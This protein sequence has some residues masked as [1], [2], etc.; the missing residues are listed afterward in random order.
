MDNV[1]DLKYEKFTLD[2]GL[3]VIL[4]R[5]TAIPSVA[6]NL[7][8]KVGSA[9]EKPGKTGLAHLFEHM[10]FQGSLNVPKEMHF[11]YIQEAGGTLNGST[12]TDRT[13]YYETLPAPALDLALWLESDRMGF[14]LPALTQEKLDNQ[15][16]VVMNERRQRYDNQP[17]GRAWEI[18]FSNL[19]PENHP[20]HWP[21]IG[22]MKDIESYTLEDVRAFFE[23]YYAPNN[24]SLV[25]AGN[26]D[27]DKA[28]KSAEQY[29]SEIKSYP[30]IPKVEI[31]DFEL[32]ENK[33]IVFEDNVQL[34]RIYLMWKSDPLYKEDDA[35]LD[36]LSDALSASKNSRLYKKLIF[37][38]QLALDVFAFQ[39]SA[40]YEGIFIIVATAK[41][42][43]SLDELK[44]LIFAELEEIY[45][46]GITESELEKAKNAIIS[47]NIYDLQYI[48]GIAN[49]LNN[50]NCT[51]GEPNSFIYDINRYENLALDDVKKAASKY[52]RKPYVELRIVPKKNSDKK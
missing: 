28:A 35:K 10:M 40:H 24:A 30:N 52:L 2:N 29:F 37:E 15:R 41:P 22:W 49:K 7:W 23:T 8:Y 25:I 9:N 38:K 20:Y 12:N 5:D 27:Y 43:V 31:P 16:E 1:L 4:Y 39:Y 26:I 50:Y 33:T 17:Y 46:N 21:T 32:Q 51:L 47:G 3:D 42:G 36:V 19:F 48:S 6:V 45:A 14:L 13:N 11:K 44:E 34:P 18:L